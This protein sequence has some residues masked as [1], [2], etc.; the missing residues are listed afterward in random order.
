MVKKL[1]IIEFMGEYSAKTKEE[2]T[3][4]AITVY[5]NFWLRFNNIFQLGGAMFSKVGPLDARAPN[6]VQMENV[7]TKNAGGRKDLDAP[8]SSNTATIR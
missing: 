1:G 3:I 4:T 5:Y 2:I 8:A 6:S 7:T